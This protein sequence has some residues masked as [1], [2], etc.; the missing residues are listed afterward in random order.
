LRLQTR[1]PPNA[2]YTSK[3]TAL[4]ASAKALNRNKGAQ[5]SF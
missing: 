2:A 3:R 1:I 4:K 5:I